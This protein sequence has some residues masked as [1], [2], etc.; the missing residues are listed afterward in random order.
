[1]KH[2][3]LVLVLLAMCPRVL[4]AQASVKKPIHAADT[5]LMEMYQLLRQSE[6]QHLSDSIR[7]ALLQEEWQSVKNPKL[8]E[9]QAYLD[10][11]AEVRVQDSL[12]LSSQKE[13]IRLLREKTKAAPVK[14]Y[15]DTLFSIYTSLGPFSPERRVQDAE[16]KIHA[17]YKQADFIPDSLTINK[18]QG[19]INITYGGEVITS[20]NHTDALW[21]DSDLDSLAIRYLEAIRTKVQAARKA[22]SFEN[23]LVHI[24]YSLLVLTGL[25][26]M[27]WL[28]N[29]SFR[30]IKYHL[31]ARKRKSF[32]SIRI[33]NYELLKPGHLLSFT[34]RLM[35][36]VRIVCIGLLIYL[37]LGLIF[38][39]FPETRTWTHTLLT[40][41]W[42]PVKDIGLATFHY[43]PRLFKIVII[44]IVTRAVVRL[45]HFFS[46]ETEKGILKIK[47]FYAE[48]ARPTYNLIRFMLYAFSF[49]I[50]FPYLPG[51]ESLAF[52]GVSVFLGILFSIGSSSAISN[53]VAGFVIT[54]M[55]PFK[56]GDWIQ[57]NDIKGYV[58]EKTV[59]ITRVR[60]IHNEDVTIPNS[61]VL[62]NHTVNY[63]SSASDLG[64]IVNATATIAYGTNWEKVHHLLIKAA[65]MTKDVDPAQ[66]PFVF[67]TAL[68]DFYA[69]YQI[70]A[71]TSKPERM[72]HIHSELHQNIQTVFAEAGIDI[73][74]PQQVTLRQEPL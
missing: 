51:S 4:H 46:L 26:L 11:I 33:R 47:G 60:T 44:I 19:L 61:A 1:M 8:S 7:I 38:S 52:K 2:Y 71:Y 24:G 41:I 35:N 25:G 3:I 17:L 40:W 49:V 34:I 37:S 27:L 15:A 14:L 66:T 58:V 57:I 6:I 29:F 73:M 42:Q 65:L 69:S 36:G 59:L 62:S 39:F 64:L 30:K 70:N 55:R 56:T 20:I 21:M 54:Y 63:S 5:A 48:W 45:V 67:Q 28:L 16:N 12:R 72:Y 9:Q 53:T 22:H 23:I 32:R 13:A 68:N 31:V 10:R 74:S 43:L 50:I 18:Q